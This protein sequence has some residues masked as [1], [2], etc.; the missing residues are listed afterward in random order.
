MRKSAAVL[1][2]ILAVVMLL[3]IGCSSEAEPSPTPIPTPEPTPTATPE[4][5]PPPTPTPTVAPTPTPVETAPPG[6]QPPCRF[7]GTVASDGAD[8]PDGTVI[9]ATILGSPYTTTT[10]ALVNGEPVYGSSTY[11]IKISE[12]IGASYDGATVSFAI[13][14]HTAAQTGT[15]AMGN[16]IKLDLTASTA[17]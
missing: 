10:P 5:T 1:V 16:N 7:Y 2:T 14:E 9:T 4:P 15:W 3:A 11:V 12:P 8:V 17:P 13:G 6:T